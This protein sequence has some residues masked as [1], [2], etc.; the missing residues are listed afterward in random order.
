MVRSTYLTVR[1]PRIRS[2][3]R[4]PHNGPTTMLSMSRPSFSAAEVAQAAEVQIETLRSWIKRGEIMLVKEESEDLRHP[5]TG[6]SR[7]FSLRRVLHIALMARL[8]R[9]TRLTPACASRVALQW[10]DI[11]GDADGGAMAVWEGGK[12]DESK[13]RDPGHLFSTGRTLFVVWHGLTDEDDD[14]PEADAVQVVGNDKSI[15]YVFGL[16]VRRTRTAES[17]TI[18]DL[19]ELDLQVRARLG[20]DRG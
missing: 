10:S 18:I 9:A 3:A 7:R 17:V 8:L 14:L 19:N 4:A 16:R 13:I 2:G 15:D 5:G 12:I 20:V 1:M 11:G 6:R